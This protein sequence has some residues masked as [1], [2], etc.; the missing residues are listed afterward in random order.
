VSL[1]TELEEIE[2]SECMDV[3]DDYINSDAT[4]TQYINAFNRFMRYFHLKQPQYLLDISDQEA[5]SYFKKYMNY[6][7]DKAKTP[8]Y[9][10]NTIKTDI[11]GVEFFF[12]YN[13]KLLNFKKLR[14]MIP[15][16]Q[17]RQ[18][19]KAYTYDQIRLM[20]SF[21]NDIRSR[22]LIQAFVN[23]G[24]RVGAMEEV[25]LKHVHLI[26]NCYYIEFYEEE[27]DFSYVGFL[28]PETSR[29]YE[30]WIAY[31]KN[32]N[33]VLTNES[34]LFTNKY[35]NSQLTHSGIRKIIVRIL[36]R[37]GIRGEKIGHGY[38]NQ[39]DH[40]FRKFLG[41]QIKDT[42][43]ITFSET[44]RML[45]HN[46]KLEAEYYDPTPEKLFE[47]FKLVIP[48]ITFDNVLQQKE[49]IKQLQGELKEKELL[50]DQVERLTNA[51]KELQNKSN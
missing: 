10:V 32:R 8:K 48:K 51:V 2:Q 11:G 42:V 43:G 14:K 22:F 37:S 17:K 23:T 49:E 21:T 45:G 27:E 34:A 35:D 15:H 46:V 39:P 30:K 9:S 20:L 19:V 1:K 16:R 38:A 6:L 47:V 36:Q 41:T 40:A 7:K 33:E 50:K 13:D 28:T 18:G 25:K 24:A 29:L 5:Y 4:R 44:E 31:R 3:F 26:E 12:T